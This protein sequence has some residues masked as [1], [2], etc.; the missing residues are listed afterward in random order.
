MTNKHM[1][2]ML[3]IAHYQRNENQNYNEVPSEWPSVQSLQI[4]NAG[5]GVEKREPSDTVGGNVSWY[6]HYGKQYGGST[7]N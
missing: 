6:S 7:E 3:N 4:T 1:K 5:Q 2:K